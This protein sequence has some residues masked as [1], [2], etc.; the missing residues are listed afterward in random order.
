[1]LML[2]NPLILFIVIAVIFG[3]LPLIMRSNVVAMFMSLFVGEAIA[4]LLAQDI[5]DIISST[6]NLNIPVYNI[7]QICLLITAPLILLFLT[8]KSIGPAGFIMQ[9]VP[10]VAL[11][12]V[13]FVFI[14]AKLPY[15]Q[16][17]IVEGSK[18]YALAKPYMGILIGAALV[19]CI[20]YFM[21][22]GSKSDHKK[23]H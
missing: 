7:V 5:T 20:L 16:Q 6:V 2:M 11:V 23:K 22:H 8:K 10:A 3:V 1:M 12:V 4:G 19:F 9:I 21:S 13:C 18:Y 17:Q 14:S 15:D